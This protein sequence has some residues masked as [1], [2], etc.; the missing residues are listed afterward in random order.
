LW[1]RQSCLQ[2]GFQPARSFFGIVSGKDR[3]AKP[4]KFH[5]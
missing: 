1:G 2:A 3:Y 5:A 4:E